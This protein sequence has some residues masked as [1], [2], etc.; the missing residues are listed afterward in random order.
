MVSKTKCIKLDELSDDFLTKYQNLYV[1]QGINKLRYP[2]GNSRKYIALYFEEILVALKVIDVN[3]IKLDLYLIS[4]EHSIL[5]FT[6]LQVKEKLNYEKIIIDYILKDYKCAGIINYSLGYDNPSVDNNIINEYF[7]STYDK[8]IW[9]SFLTKCDGNIDELWKSYKSKIRYDVKKSLNQG[10]SIHIISNI[11]DIKD[12]FFIYKE[13][14]LRDSVNFRS[15]ESYFNLLKFTILS[16]NRFA[17]LIKQN[18]NLIA[19]AVFIYYGNTMHWGSLALSNFARKN[20]I[21][22]MHYLNWWAIEKANELN[23]EFFDTVGYNPNKRTQREEGIYT[24]KKK[25]SNINLKYYIISKIK[26]YYK[27]FILLARMIKRKIIVS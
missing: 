19:T 11:E 27:P 26:W 3:V 22:A 23:L 14:R 7:D 20:K 16:E 4:S 15:K 1:A 24:F 21:N 6:D 8:K 17:V 25:L 13:S 12:S 2:S 9:G 18:N 5:Y 10:L